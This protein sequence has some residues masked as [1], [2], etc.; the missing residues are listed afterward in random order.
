MR[1]GK[2]KGKGKAVNDSQRCSRS[3]S[4]N[5]HTNAALHS[6][7]LLLLLPPHSLP[8]F[9]VSPDSPVPQTKL[10][11]LV[12]VH[13]MFHR[14]PQQTDTRRGEKRR[15]EGGEAGREKR[16]KQHKAGALTPLFLVQVASGL[17]N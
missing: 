12:A 6:L 1:N 11:Q 16:G 15:G 2:V 7:L 13:A 14:H 4:I 9:A 3:P 17:P 10:V 8:G 5:C